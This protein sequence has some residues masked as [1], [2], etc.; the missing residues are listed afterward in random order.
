MVSQ[1]LNVQVDSW[2]S[3]ESR[4]DASP[5]LKSRKPLLAKYSLCLNNQSIKTL[6]E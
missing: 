3:V 2:I 5:R 6:N 1:E 4:Y